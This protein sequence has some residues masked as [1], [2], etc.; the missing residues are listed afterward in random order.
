M[1]QVSVIFVHMTT[2]LYP[3]PRLL[4]GVSG[5]TLKFLGVLAAAEQLKMLILLCITHYS[6]EISKMKTKNRRA[7][8][9]HGSGPGS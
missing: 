1:W 4:C 9:Y 8:L 2:E 6:E 3:N 7:S 5:E